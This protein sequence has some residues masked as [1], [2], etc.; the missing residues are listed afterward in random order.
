MKRVLLFFSLIATI[1]NCQA[2]S[3]GNDV[4]K[5]G[6]KGKVK[7]MEEARFP[8]TRQVNG[9]WTVVDTVFYNVDKYTFD[10]SGKLLSLENEH[11]QVAGR[12]RMTT[13]ITKFSYENN[14]ISGSKT[15]NDAGK[16]I[17]Y[18][19]VDWS[20]NETYTDSSADKE[21]KNIVLH[22]L[23][24][25][26]RNKETIARKYN[27]NNKLMMSITTKFSY[28]KFGRVVKETITDASSGNTYNFEFKTLA[29]DRDGNRTKVL[30]TDNVKGGMPDQ[31][32]LYNYEYYK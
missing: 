7:V 28:D 2:Q 3:G 16:E 5:Y 15:Y 22:I 11:H 6:L 21:T 23:D 27:R 24:K 18:S 13:T 17:N 9:E 4:K 19:V 20:D 29:K 25:D 8:Y 26:M 12:R 31:L 10:E 32:F 14:R 1:F 30:F